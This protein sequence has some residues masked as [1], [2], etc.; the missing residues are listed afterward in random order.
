MILAA[1]WFRYDIVHDFLNIP[2]FSAALRRMDLYDQHVHSRHSFDSQADPA[3]VVETAIARGLTGVTFTEHFDTHA[4]D[5]KTCTYD[6]DA[7]SITIEGLRA[8]FAGAIF[9]GKGIEICCQPRRMDFILDFLQD[10]EFDMVMLSVHYFGSQALHVREH[11]NGLSAAEGTRRYLATVLEAVRLCE[12]LHETRGRVFDVLGHLDFVKRYSQ[13]FLGT[14]DVS[15]FDGLL[16]EIL[17]TCIAADLVP[18]INTSTWRRQMDEPMPGA[19]T[20]ARYVRLGGTAM[21]LGSDAHRSQD[22]G[23]DFDR[24]VAMLRAVGIR[25]APVFKKRE[26]LTMAI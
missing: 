14:Y 25:G 17:G 21:S 1:G 12:A 3:A 26:R 8:K 24:A 10:H 2:V 15:G 16:D 7:Y 6:D 13:R 11:W 23:A 9:I 22:V 20:I 4:D 5:W 18:E 19:D